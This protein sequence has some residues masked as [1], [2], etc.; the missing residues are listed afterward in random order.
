MVANHES[1]FDYPPWP[2]PKA[3]RRSRILLA[4]DD[5]DMRQLL[6]FTLRSEGYEVA[7]CA[8]GTELLE[9]LMAACGLH[10]SYHLD[11]VISDIRMP[12]ISGL[13]VLGRVRDCHDMPPIM[14]ITAFGDEETHAQARQLGAVASIDKP[15][16]ISQFLALVHTL[17]VSPESLDDASNDTS[18]PF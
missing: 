2:Q 5:A 3:D 9:Q 10:A 4:D 6:A 18:D 11:L 8:D 15:F 7:A 14:V 13:E 17:I 1:D 16:E 12:G